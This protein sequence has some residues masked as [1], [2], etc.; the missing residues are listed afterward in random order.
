MRR[1]DVLSAWCE[2]SG[3]SSG[4]RVIILL[5]ELPM[6][7]FVFFFFFLC[8]FFWVWLCCGPN[9]LVSC[10]YHINIVGR[11]PISR[12]GGPRH[13]GETGGSG[14]EGEAR[15]GLLGAAV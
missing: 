6:L 8:S 14:G 13:N 5:V 10:G 15:R 12:G 4:L 11:K 3:G 9:M 7:V 1:F 2:S